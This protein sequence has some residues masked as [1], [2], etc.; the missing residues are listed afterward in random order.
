MAILFFFLMNRFKYIDIFQLNLCTFVEMLKK[1]DSR[2][3]SVILII[4]AEVGL[5][6]RDHITLALI[7][8]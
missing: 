5:S 7:L 1:N 8:I 2:G 6:W 4:M 3:H